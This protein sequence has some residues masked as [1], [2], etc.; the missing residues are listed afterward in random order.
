MRALT[1]RPVWAHSVAHLDK[2]IENR[3]W[4]PPESIRGQR[5][6]IHAG[7]RKADRAER[8]TV[9]VLRALGYVVPDDMPRGCVVAV[10]RV[11]GWR[12]SSR[13]EVDGGWWI[14]PVGW[15]LDDVVTLARPVPSKG[16]LGLWE[17]S[18][19]VERAVREALR[20]KGG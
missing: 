20:E 5:I 19:S 18:E 11:T 6:A 4:E 15:E 14:G 10:A 3:T 9:A 12:Y 7:L 13:P 16:L 8:E 1:L 2:R 17:M